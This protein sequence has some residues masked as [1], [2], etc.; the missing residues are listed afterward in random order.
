[1]FFESY[2]IAPAL[3]MERK[4][5]AFYTEGGLSPGSALL[6]QP[7]SLLEGRVRSPKK[8]DL[9]GSKLQGLTCQEDIGT[10]QVSA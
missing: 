1:M 2:S 10:Q 7:Q 6:A 8:S 3:T 9:H 4:G 5:F